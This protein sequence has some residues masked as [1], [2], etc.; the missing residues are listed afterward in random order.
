MRLTPRVTKFKVLPSYS[1]EK[2]IL[3]SVLPS[4]SRTPSDEDLLSTDPEADS[5]GGSVDDLHREAIS[6]SP[7]QARAHSLQ[8]SRAEYSKDSA[9]LKLPGIYSTVRSRIKN[10]RASLR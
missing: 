7:R 1:Q 2:A 4:L 5:P 9:K 8:Y 6:P 10:S 3:T